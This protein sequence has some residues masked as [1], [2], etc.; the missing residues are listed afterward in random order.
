MQK[1]KLQR[2]LPG[3]VVEPPQI[4]PP[5]TRPAEPLSDPK[6][7]AVLETL[8]PA[9][10]AVPFPTPAPPPTRVEEQYEPSERKS[11]STSTTDIY[12]DIITAN[13]K[14]ILIIAETQDHLV[15]FNQPTTTDS[16]KVFSSGSLSMTGKGIRRIYAKTTTGTGTLRILVFK[17]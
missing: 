14:Q 16:P 11:I 4:L 10:V 3:L 7:V 17:A 15:D 6:H 1:Q 9:P 13:P 2:Q 8:L 5:F 12:Y